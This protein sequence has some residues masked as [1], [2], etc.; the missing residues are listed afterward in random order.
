MLSVYVSLITYDTFDVYCMQ[1]Y[2]CTVAIYCVIL[3]VLLISIFK[4]K[5]TIFLLLFSF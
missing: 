3:F 1:S 5:K 2:I 4:L